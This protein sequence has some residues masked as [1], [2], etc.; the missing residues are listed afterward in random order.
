MDEHQ[1]RHLLGNIGEYTDGALAG[2]LCAEIERHLENCPNCQ[3]VVNTL[4]K[5]VE[6]YHDTA[7]DDEMPGAV[8][9]R[10]F[11]CLDLGEYL[12]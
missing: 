1:C 2:E 12:K 6:L 5:T 11:A 7:E 10:L 9:A 3:I 4:R 8:R